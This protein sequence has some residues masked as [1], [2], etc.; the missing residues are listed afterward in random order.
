MDL[1]GYYINPHNKLIGEDEIMNNCWKQN[2]ILVTYE[3]EDTI[4]RLQTL[5][6]G[7]LRQMLSEPKHP[8]RL[9][10]KSRN[11]YTYHK[12]SV[13]VI[14][15]KMVYEL[16]TIDDDTC[17]QL[18]IRSGMAAIICFTDKKVCFCGNHQ[19]FDGMNGLALV[20]KF[21]DHQYVP[22]IQELTYVPI[23]TELNLLQTSWPC[24]LNLPIKN[25]TYS[26][27]WKDYSS[28]SISIQSRYNLRM[29]KNEKNK[30]KISFNSLMSAVL[31][32]GLFRSSKINTLSIGVI[33]SIKS[34]KRFNNYGIVFVNAKRSSSFEELAICIDKQLK[35]CYH[36]GALTYLM[37]NL[38]E[39]KYDISVDILLSGVPL[40]LEKPV[41]IQG[42]AVK[43]IRNNQRYS[44]RSVYCLYL[45]C[46]RYI[47]VNV[48]LRTPDI[49]IDCLKQ[50]L[51]ERNI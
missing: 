18:A 23:V 48:S 51:N 13:N 36:A 28:R 38:Y 3:F 29:F 7:V 26:P 40:S 21:F 35:R 20:Q 50:C 5:I 2:F 9:K 43:H 25:L 42:V 4:P 6:L 8:L 34:A 15:T 41:S 10:Y 11:T 14:L 44:S 39:L 31:A 46:S 49:D 47:H 37:N 16:K 32:D 19:F 33:V 12:Y 1:L 22:K 17:T 45:S 30:Y 24:L 27:H